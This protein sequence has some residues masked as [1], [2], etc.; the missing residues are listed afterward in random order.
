MRDD[1]E[2]LRH[3]TVR[4]VLGTEGLAP[5]L[6]RFGFRSLFRLLGLYQRSRSDSETITRGQLGGIV[7]T[8][9]SFLHTLLFASQPCFLASVLYFSMASIWGNR[10]LT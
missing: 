5:R 6:L 7:E 3:E 9:P 8:S 10:T 4:S 1:W 2:L